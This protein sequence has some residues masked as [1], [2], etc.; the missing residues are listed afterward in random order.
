MLQAIACSNDLLVLTLKIIETRIQ[1]HPKWKHTRI[2]KTI[3]SS[4]Q[5]FRH[6]AMAKSGT[7]KLVTFP[8]TADKFIHPASGTIAMQ[9][10]SLPRQLYHWL[11][12]KTV[13]CSYWNTVQRARGWQ[14]LTNQ[15]KL[16]SFDNNCLRRVLQIYW[17]NVL[18]KRLHV[19]HK[20]TEIKKENTSALHGYRYHPKTA[21][22]WTPEGK[23][24]VE[25]PRKTW[26]RIAD[27][28]RG[29]MGWDFWHQA[30]HP[31]KDRAGW[32]A[33]IVALRALLH[34]TCRENLVR[35]EKDI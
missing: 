32:R 22:T 19:F 10:S 16:K 34:L 31:A 20:S 35:I 27:K 3:P 4:T 33:D 15:L 9:I 24:S 29:E 13:F 30:E 2:E 12:L 28:E 26:R 1:F 8:R 11:A 5:F 14:K 7:T 25:R 17:P 21:L 6:S 18:S 23:R